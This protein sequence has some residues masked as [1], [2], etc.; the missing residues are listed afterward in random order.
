MHTGH[1]VDGWEGIEPEC[2]VF[3]KVYEHQSWQVYEWEDIY[4]TASAVVQGLDIPFD[5]RHVLISHAAVQHW[6]KDGRKTSN[7][8]SQVMEV[9]RKPRW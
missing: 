8:G 1:P 3:Q 2:T 9:T 7:L 4:Y 5:H 6:G